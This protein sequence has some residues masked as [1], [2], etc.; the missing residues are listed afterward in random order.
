M[1]Y[2]I[3]IGP[4]AFPLW[5]PVLIYFVG[6]WISVQ[7]R[8]IPDWDKD[9]YRLPTTGEAIRIVWA[10]RD[11]CLFFFGITVGLIFLLD[12]LF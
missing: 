11:A 2:I 7:F 5:L 4:S 8:P 1:N 9:R 10:E 6:V 3:T 12:H